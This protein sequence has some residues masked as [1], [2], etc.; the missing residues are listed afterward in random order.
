MISG[1]SPLSNNRPTPFTP[2]DLP[3][4]ECLDALRQALKEGH[5][6]LSATPGSGKTTVVPPALLDE[7]WLTGKKIVML[8]PRR[9]AARMAAHRIAFLLGEKVGGRVGYQVRFER[10]ISQQTRIEVLT[11]GLLL[12]R[13]QSDPELSDVG[14]LIFDEYHERS[15]V[16]DLSLA[17]SLDICLGLR[18]DLRLLVMSASLDEGAVS[19]LLNARQIT[20]SGQLH[21]VTLHHAER[22][23][24]LNEVVGACM[25]LIQKALDTVAGDLLVFLPG[26]GE[27]DRLQTLARQRWGGVC[28]LLP[29]HGGLS[30]EQQDRV[31]RP[32]KRGRR[33][34]ILSTD[35]AE[36]SLTIEGVE[37]V[38]DGGRAR[39]PVFQPNSGLTRLETRW[40]SKA[41]ALQRAGRAGRLGPG[42]CF[43]AWTEARQNRL[44][45]WI[46]PEIL[47]ADLAPL[48]LEL[49]AWG[50]NRSEDMAW[51][52]PPP[53]GHWR[54][55]VDLLYQLQALDRQGQI[56]SQ[57][58]PLPSLP[59]HP[60]LAH[61]LPAA[62]GA[63]DQRLAVDI[64]ALL[65]DRDPLLRRTGERNPVDL[66]LRLTALNDWRQGHKLLGFD[67]RTLQ[68][69]DRLSQQFLNML[70]KSSRNGKGRWSTGACLA[71]AYPDR[72]AKRRATGGYLMRN[73][74]GVTLPQ[75]DAL[76]FSNYLVIADLD[77]GQREG[78]V[79]LASEISVGE[80]EQLFDGQI[81]EGRVV[82]WDTNRQAAV[83]RKRRTLGR[84]VLDERQIPLSP[85]DSVL[86][87]CWHRCGHK[88]CHCSESKRGSTPC[89]PG[90]RRCAEWNPMVIG[91][92]YQKRGC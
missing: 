3:I 25:P 75:E 69:L 78:R 30:A 82:Y 21:P 39:K 84:I 61:M 87:C 18:E 76:A 1:I 92:I 85:D 23:C 16:A 41:S 72:V 43:R 52:D 46:R 60:R 44:E 51:L 83:A 6:T 15:L 70:P 66:T 26:R 50:V 53:K 91:R 56:T 71:M 49:A 81:E 65:S 34:L 32:A 40:I 90:W 12:R 48:V 73:G 59:L 62:E 33:R 77:A 7:P 31:L 79:W 14:L 64:A 19:R 13:L 10:R 58:E 57:A 74:R 20:A 24:P 89:A 88:G 4:K 36:T 86:I 37:A 63:L 67:H 68:Q 42:H 9:P 22:D 17:L 28:D 45:D 47:D 2:P 27:I 55:A 38:I 11:E 8:E 80:I 5:V 54:Q 29:L 35:I